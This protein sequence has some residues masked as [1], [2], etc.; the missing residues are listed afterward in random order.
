MIRWRFR[1]KRPVPAPVRTWPHPWTPWGLPL[2]LDYPPQR[3]CGAPIA[4]TEAVYGGKLTNGWC[5]R[6]IPCRYHDT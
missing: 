1:R 6:S 3:M 4:Q 2:Y 5:E